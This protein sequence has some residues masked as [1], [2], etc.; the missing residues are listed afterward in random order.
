MISHWFHYNLVLLNSA[1]ELN[2]LLISL[3]TVRAD[4]DCYHFGLSSK[5]ERNL[6]I[7]PSANSGPTVVSRWRLTI[8]VS[9]ATS[10]ANYN[11]IASA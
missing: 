10:E 5:F 2:L 8:V 1:T 4:S 7:E 9:I 3:V 6:S 11:A